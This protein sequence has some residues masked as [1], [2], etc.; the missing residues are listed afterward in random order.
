MTDKNYSKWIPTGV[1]SPPSRGP[2]M[3]DKIK[4]DSGQA[5]KI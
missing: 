2:G 4:K 5:G 1:Y 3:T